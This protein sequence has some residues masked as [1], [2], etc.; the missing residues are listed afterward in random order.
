MKRSFLHT[1]LVLTTIVIASGS[2]T[3]AGDSKNR[4]GSGGFNRGSGNN[5][6]GQSSS[7]FSGR[8]GTLSSN[9]GN[10]RGHSGNGG[11]GNGNS[12][13]SNISGGSAQ[14]QHGFK[15]P[16]HGNNGIKQHVNQ[17]APFQLPGRLGKVG[18]PEVKVNLPSKLQNHTRHAGQTILLPNGTKTK[19]IAINVSQLLK[20]NGHSVQGQHQ[21]QNIVASAP[22]HLCGQPHFSW[23]VNVCHNHCHTNYG[24]WNVHNHYWDCWTPCN[25]QVVRCEQFTYY[26]GLNCTYIPDMQAYGVQSVNGGSPAQLAGL[27]PGDLILSVNGQPVFDPNLVN[28]ELV[29]GRLDLQVIREGSPAPILLTVFPRLVQNLSF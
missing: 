11:L 29:R 14:R 15:L 21:I 18:I 8:L 20:H 3:F 26:L 22:K 12:G 6:G 19:S 2:T 17:N 9:N 25:W 7:S 23:W 13:G 16:H 24:C 10:K 28:S 4:I 5:N 1:A 27:Q